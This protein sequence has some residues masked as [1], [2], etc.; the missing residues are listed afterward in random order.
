MHID[1]HLYTW[2]NLYLLRPREGHHCASLLSS[3]LLML[4][5]WV[6]TAVSTKDLCL[7]S[8]ILSFYHFYSYPFL[9]PFIVLLKRIFAEPLEI[10]VGS[11]TIL[12][13][14]SFTIARSSSW[15]VIPLCC[16]VLQPSS[17][18]LWCGP[19][20]KGLKWCGSI[21]FSTHTVCG[22]EMKLPQPTHCVC[23]N[24]CIEII[25]VPWRQLENTWLK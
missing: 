5:L 21:S 16:T 2:P 6:I 19:N 15:W 12:N 7:H 14:L 20:V 18:H 8:K 13:L 11:R 3:F 4:W 24:K 25:N 1:N 17:A 9:H 23:R 10:V 22:L